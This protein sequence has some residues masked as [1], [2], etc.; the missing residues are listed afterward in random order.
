MAGAAISLSPLALA[1]LVLQRYFVQS[2]ATT[3]IK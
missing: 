2:V 3:G 1:F